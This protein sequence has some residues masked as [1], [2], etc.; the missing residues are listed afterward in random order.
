MDDVHLKHHVV[1]HKIGE[2]RLVGDDAAHL[3]GGEEY[4]FGLLLLEETVHGL[5]VDEVEF[6]VGAGDD[7]VVALTA[8]LA[9]DGGAYHAAVA[10]YVD[11]RI[12]FH[13]FLYLYRLD[14]FLSE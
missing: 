7:I 2:R 12:F 5:L 14:S 8:K 1:V 11:F 3:G 10:G 6:L 9:H 13:N 4:V